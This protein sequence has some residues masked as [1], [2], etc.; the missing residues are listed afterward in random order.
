[1]MGKV[2]WILGVVTGWIFKITE[3]IPLL[4]LPII[5][6]VGFTD[7]LG[8]VLKGR[9]GKGRRKE[10]GRLGYHLGWKL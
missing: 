10:E 9:P 4:D 1:M 5:R 3:F 7:S 2:N 6:Q 8:E